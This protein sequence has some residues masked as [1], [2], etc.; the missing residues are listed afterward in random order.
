VRSSG[1]RSYKCIYPFRGRTRWVHLARADAIALPQARLLAQETMLAVARGGDPAGDRQAARAGAAS[2][3]ATFASLHRRY[4]SEHASRHNKS[5]RLGEHLVVRWVLP[6]WAGLSPT[7]IGRADVR[8]LLGHLGHAPSLANS[9]LGAVSAV[10]TWA[11]DQDLLPANPARGIKR[12]RTQSRE[13]ILA[14]D[15][16]GKFWKAWDQHGLQHATALRLI[17]LTAQRPGEICHMRWE[18]LSGDGWWNMPGHPTEGW[19]GTKNSQGHSVWVAPQ[20]LALIEQFPRAATGF[21]LAGPRGSAPSHLTE[22]MRAVCAR[23]G[24]ERCTPHDL[25]RTACSTVTKLG[26]GRDAMN[27]ISNHRDGGIASV[28]DRHE[29]QVENQK[30]WEAIAAHIAAMVRK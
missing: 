21:V 1:A 5:W 23:L 14:P 30:V 10:F 28:Y 15:E 16:I 24:V 11:V 27:R 26:F 13:R 29:Y 12:Q 22:T 20:V 8:A 6:H 19:P 4:L 17:L 7:T 2:T 3:R 18:H 25:R 9:V